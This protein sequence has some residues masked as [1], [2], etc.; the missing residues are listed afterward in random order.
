[1]QSQGWLAQ[2][3]SR[4]RVRWVVA[5]TVWL[6]TYGVAAVVWRVLTDKSWLDAFAFAGTVAVVNVV[7]QWVAIRAK[8]KAEERSG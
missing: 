5:V 2:L 1:M 3:R 4:R 7:A 6:A 8:R